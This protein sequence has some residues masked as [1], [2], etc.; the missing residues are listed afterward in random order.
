MEKRTGRLLSFA[1][2]VEKLANSR[3]SQEAQ[4]AHQL[5]QRVRAARNEAEEDKLA[6]QFSG[7]FG[8]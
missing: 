5:Y 3:R 4:E 7:T 1:N 2:V 6:N 8:L